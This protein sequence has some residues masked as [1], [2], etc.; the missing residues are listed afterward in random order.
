MEE[1]KFTNEMRDYHSGEAYCSAYI[2]H[3]NKIIGYCDYSCFK[4]KIHIEMIQV[5]EPF[6]RTGLATKLLDFIKKENPGETIDPGY[7]TE[8]GDKFYRAYQK[9]NSQKITEVMDDYSSWKR[10]NIAYRGITSGDPSL[11]NSNMFGILGSG[12]Y[13]T[14]ASNKAMSRQYGKLYFAVNGR[15][16]HPKVFRS[17]NDWEIWFQNHLI[18]PYSKATGKNYPDLRDFNAHTNIESEM[19]KLGYDGIE[20]LGREIVNFNPEN[21]KYFKTENEV[22]TYYDSLNEMIENLNESKHTISYIGYVKNNQ[23]NIIDYITQLEYRNEKEVFTAGYQYVTPF[24]SFIKDK[25][26]KWVPYNFI[27]T[28]GFRLLDRITLE[29]GTITLNVGELLKEENQTLLQ[30]WWNKIYLS[31]EILRD[32][33]NNM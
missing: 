23:G 19:Q 22:K 26:K 9:K 25:T 28:R 15:P 1:F 12:L 31:Q 4:K 27:K 21:V 17:I 2:W 7:S 18:L 5:D 3:E 6:R 10:K 11:P 33:M 13:M 16:K 8:E 24:K 29:K 32:V 20:I 14:P 30:S